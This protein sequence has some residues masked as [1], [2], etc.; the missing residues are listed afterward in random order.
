MSLTDIKKEMKNLK[1][2]KASYSSDIPTKTLKQNVDFFSLFILGYANKSIS[3]STFP[4]I[5]K[6][7]DI[8]PIYTKD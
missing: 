5:L 8:T 4:S 6:L 3:S 2:N 1:T 7:A